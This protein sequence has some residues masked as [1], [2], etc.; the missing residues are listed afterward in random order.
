MPP[1]PLLLLGTVSAA[2]AATPLPAL[3][4]KV[5]HHLVSQFSE[6]HAMFQHFGISTFGANNSLGIGGA[7]DCWHGAT[8]K[9]DA[10][11]HPCLPAKLFNPENYSAAQTMEVA[12]AFGAS[13]VCI[14]AHHEGGFTLWPSSYSDYGVGASAWK[15]G[16][17]DIL[18]EFAAAARAAGIKIC[19]YIG[20]NANGYM[21]SQNYTAEKFVSAQLG[22]FTELLTNPDYGPVNRCDKR[23]CLRF[24]GATKR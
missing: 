2:A 13:E 20:P 11:T 21:I 5:Y 8:V 15:G 7:N 14:T 24:V 18:K 9:P 23:F 16:K 12:K 1:L 17:G 22:E 3:N 10:V 6:G 19:Y 4:D